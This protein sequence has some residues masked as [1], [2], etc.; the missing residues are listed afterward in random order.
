MGSRVALGGER[1]PDQLLSLL[2]KLI[3]DLLNFLHLK[4]DFLVHIFI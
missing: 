2:F 4:L 1:S 3:H